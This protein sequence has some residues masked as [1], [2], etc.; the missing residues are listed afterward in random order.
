MKLRPLFAMR[1]STVVGSLMSALTGLA[2]LLGSSANA[3]VAPTSPSREQPRFASPEAMH[4]AYAERFRTAPG[5]GMSRVIQIG[6]RFELMARGDKTYQFTT[7]DLIALENQPKVYRG[8]TELVGMAVITNKT[9]RVRLKT[10]ALTTEETKA[11]AELRAGSDLALL[12][13]MT[14]V[15]GEHPEGQDSSPEVPGLLVVGALRAKATCAECHQ[16]KEGTLLGA[17]AY[18]LVPTNAVSGRAFASAAVPR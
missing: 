16:V 14:A 2:V 10:R 12:A 3:Q 18:T 7:P 4:A 8:G 11:V 9:A 17:F 5:F 1:P 6:P 15:P 13:V